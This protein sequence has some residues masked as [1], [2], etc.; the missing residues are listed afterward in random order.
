MRYY[1]DDMIKFEDLILI[2]FNKRK[3]IR[4]YFDL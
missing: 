4:K 3:I 2:I 1:F